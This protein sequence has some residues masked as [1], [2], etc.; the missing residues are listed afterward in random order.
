MINNK[1]KINYDKTEFLVITKPHLESHL[2][3]LKMEIRLHSV[4]VSKDTK[5]CVCGEEHDLCLWV[6]IHIWVMLFMD[7]Y[8]NEDT[9]I[10]HI[11]NLKVNK[12]QSVLLD[13][14]LY[15]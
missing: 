6:M 15:M 3:D 4:P 2:K 7:S 13:Y 5:I 8:I 14:C 12:F 1:L 11:M 9:H 10:D